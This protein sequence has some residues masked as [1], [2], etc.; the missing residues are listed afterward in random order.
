MVFVASRRLATPRLAFVVDL[1]FLNLPLASRV[2][3]ADNATVGHQIVAHHQ[4]AAPASRRLLLGADEDL[5]A[6]NAKL[7]VA[8]P[9]YLRA[10]ALALIR[11]DG[12]HIVWRPAS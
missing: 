4:T 2:T 1:A 10:V 5:R 7:F 6:C 8:V 3:L 11:T 12:S 9:V